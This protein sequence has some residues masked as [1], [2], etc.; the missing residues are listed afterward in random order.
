MAVGADTTAIAMH[1]SVHY[2]FSSEVFWGFLAVAVE[3]SAFSNC[4][5]KSVNCS[6]MRTSDFETV[7]SCC[8]NR[9]MGIVPPCIRGLSR[10]DPYIEQSSPNG[11]TAAF[12]R[13]WEDIQA[14]LGV[15]DS[16]V[17]PLDAKI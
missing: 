5:A 13:F 12:N 6:E 9:L 14:F 3:D 7:E 2:F 16:F 4:M 1:I 11:T 8:V 17:T 10:S 15:I